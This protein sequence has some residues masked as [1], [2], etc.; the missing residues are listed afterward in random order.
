MPVS[1]KV[2]VSTRNSKNVSYHDF[3]NP[4]N[5]HVGKLINIK[6]HYHSR[7][8]STQ[9]QSTQLST[10]TQSQTQQKPSPDRS[11]YRKETQQS[12]LQLPPTSRLMA[13][14]FHTNQLRERQNKRCNIDTN[15]NS[16]SRR[17]SILTPPSERAEISLQ[18]IK[19]ETT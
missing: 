11:F 6:D 8:T 17:A 12:G 14:Q 5:N 2:P 1:T 13:L 16:T 9:R 15:T 4:K 19:Q 3:L 7:H 18:K 10:F